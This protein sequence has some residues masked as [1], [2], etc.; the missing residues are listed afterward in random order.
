MSVSV[1]SILAKIAAS[2]AVQKVA[3]KLGMK[4]WQTAY[5][6]AKE[7]EAARKA[8]K[9]LIV[10]I[11]LYAASGCA[12]WDRAVI[13]GTEAANPEFIQKDKVAE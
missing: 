1:V 10:A 6:R 13:A 12:Y 4:A 8:A 5:E 11:A 7:R 9:V 3:K 2:E